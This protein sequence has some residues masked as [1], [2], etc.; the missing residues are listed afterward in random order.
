MKT[1]NEFESAI[2]IAGLIVAACATMDLRLA[3]PD[4][5]GDRQGEDYSGSAM[6]QSFDLAQ[7]A[8]VGMV[9]SGAV[10]EPVSMTGLA[11]GNGRAHAP[12]LVMRSSRQARTSW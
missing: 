12:M 3:A 8:A 7:Q 10:P 2:V 4:A 1:M 5:G 6:A 11:T 9:G